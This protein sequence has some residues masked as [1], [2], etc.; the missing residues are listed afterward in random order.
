MLWQKIQWEPNFP[1]NVHQKKSK[2]CREYWE[3]AQRLQI[4]EQELSI[5]RYRFNKHM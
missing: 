5:F 1:A 3:V 4:T 2:A